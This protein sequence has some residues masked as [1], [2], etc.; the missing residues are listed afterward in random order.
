MLSIR[1]TQRVDYLGQ[2]VTWHEMNHPGEGHRDL[3]QDILD[4]FIVQ[5]RWQDLI[6]PGMVCVDIGAH[7]GDT[8]I[9]MMLL[10]KA[11]VVAI[12]PNPHILPYLEQCLQDN[13][14]LAPWVIS[15]YAITTEPGPVV[16]WDHRNSM[17][18]GGLHDPAWSGELA[19]RIRDMSGENVEV[20]GDRLESV[21]KQVLT[22]EEYR[23]IGFIKTDTE[24]HDV[25]I[26]ESSQAM[27]EELRPVIF[28]EWF[29]AYG[30]EENR[31][32]FRVIEDIG[33][34]ALDPA[35]LLPWTVR[36][37]DLVLVP[38]EHRLA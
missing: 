20:P 33:Y 38:K 9:A 4:V 31:R 25:S 35:T 29:F 37:S 22:N 26:L 5:H 23:Q 21:C 24:G 3:K 14:Q 15:H 16:I 32:M 8:T 11:K 36:T 34:V 12:E 10:S 6:T 1:S 7:S 30:D 13:T 28:M 19:A 17:C 27:I 2:S 18:N